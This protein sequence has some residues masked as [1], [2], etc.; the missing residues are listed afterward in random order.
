MTYCIELFAL[1][2]LSNM[3]SGRITRFGV[4]LSMTSSL[5]PMGILIVIPVMSLKVIPKLL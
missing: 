4:F 5:L 1:A 3:N 2:P